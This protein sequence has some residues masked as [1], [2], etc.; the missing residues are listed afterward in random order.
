MSLVLE[1]DGVSIKLW[2][3][4]LHLRLVRPHTDDPPC[5]IQPRWS[6]QSKTERC[7]SFTVNFGMQ[8]V[9]TNFHLLQHFQVMQNAR[10]TFQEVFNTPQH[11]TNQ[12]Q[13]RGIFFFTLNLHVWEVTFTLFVKSFRPFQVFVTNNKTFKLLCFDPSVLCERLQLW[14]INPNEKHAGETRLSIVALNCTQA[15]PNP[16]SQ[17]RQLSPWRK[18]LVS[19]RWSF[20]FPA[21][22]DGGGEVSEAPGKR[23]KS[24]P[25]WHFAC[26]WGGRGS[27]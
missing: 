22:V 8:H 4:T 6:Q 3:A 10:E 7:R 27:D 16:A 21:V 26:A 15:A 5:T 14:N 2:H 19:W 13:W 9:H 18:K 17:T 24:P 11:T 1:V 25:D 12:H 20:C 23:S